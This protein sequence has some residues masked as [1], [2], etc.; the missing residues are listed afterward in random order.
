MEIKKLVFIRILIAVISLEIPLLFCNNTERGE[1]KFIDSLISVMTLD[2]KI[3]QLV[4]ID[5][6]TISHE[7]AVELVREGK[8]GSLFNLGILDNCLKLQRTAVEESRL[9]IPLIIGQ[10]VI[11]GFRTIFPI[12]LAESCAWDP[13]M[14]E[15]NARIAAIEAS[16]CGVH[17]TFAPMVDIARDARW[18]RIAE[19]SGEDPYLGSILASAKVRGFQSNDLSKNNTI[20]ACPKH[21]VAYGAAEGG[22]DYNTVE[23]SL[24]TLHEIYLPPFLSAIREGALTI[25]SAFNEINGVPASANPYTLKS[26]LRDKW[27]FDGFVVSDYN[28]VNE[29][30]A[31]GFAKNMKEAAMK[32]FLAG[33]DMEMMGYTYFN[34][35]KE[36]VEEG[37]IQEEQID[38]SV[39]RIL[40]VKYRLGLFNDPYYGNK[41]REQK[42]I[43][44]KEFVKQARQSARESIVLL[45]NE[46]VLPISDKDLPLAVI[47]PLADS[48]EDLLGSWSCYGRPEDVI[49]ILE[50]L[51]EKYSDR[52]IL[53]HKG[54]EIIGGN[55]KGFQKAIKIAKKAKTILL[56]LGEASWMS[57]EAGSRAY[58]GLPGYQLELAKEIRRNT[59]KPIIAILVNGRPLAIKWLADNVDAI[60]ESWQLG[61]Q[62][63]PAVVDILSGDYNPSGKL[64]VTFPQA[65]GQEPIY[66]NHKN[67][68]RP[69]VGERRR[70]V[71]W[72][73]DLPYGVLYPFG[74]GLSYSKFD[75][76]DLEIYPRS[77]SI[78]DTL[79]IKFKITNKSN[80]A[81]KEITQLYIRDISASI[82]RPV[83]ELKRFKKIM[84]SPKET[85]K[86]E[87]KLPIREC[88]FYNENLEYVIEP[89]LFKLWVGPNSAEGLEG[90]FIVK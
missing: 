36:L 33:V 52:N 30:I 74:Y 65:T 79:H 7:R 68:G 58:I 5:Y 90:E 10:D 48:K 40:K 46:G 23:I 56:V 72:Y 42:E 29:L 39:R 34:H 4:Q 17:W 43:L 27:K 8:V 13:K 73:V 62:H 57:G 19:G 70:Y 38:K 31:H 41:E 47:G 77:L 14:S 51:R 22:R 71:S 2:E 76:H 21:Y 3:G 12:P 15:R 26:I 45:K 78:N 67:T 60:V 64:T 87:F 32:A 89:G 53:Y 84:I 16:A 75:Y 82:T 18:G 66:Y 49:S 61:I 83:K 28:A 69:P 81:G 35:M 9:G 63:G 86:I 11:H 59:N 85:V 20:V 24:I 50:A 1:N 44:K 37:T 88:G 6:G 80:I 25:M 54:C 55:K